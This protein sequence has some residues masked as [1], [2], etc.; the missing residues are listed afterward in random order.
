MACK[1]MF[2]TFL[3]GCLRKKKVTKT[4]VIC[5]QQI[6]KHLLSGPLQKM[7]TNLFYINGLEL[8]KGFRK[9]C[10]IRMIILA[11]LWKM[12]IKR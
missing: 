3:K 8:L 6:L 9:G 4:Y 10:D 5:D 1:L 7:F 12:N 2:F 11:V